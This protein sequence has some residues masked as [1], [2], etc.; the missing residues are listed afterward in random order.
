MS[1]P[2]RNKLK[3]PID[4]GNYGDV[5]FAMLLMSIVALLIIPLP[6]F[7]LDILLAT[8]IAIAVVL[9]LTSIYVTKPLKLSTFP[10]ILLVATLFRLALNVSS[11][12]LILGKGYAGEVIASFGE[13]VVQGNYVVGA[14]IFLILTLIQFLVIAKGS[15]RVAEVAARFTLDAMPGK[16]MS[17]DADLRAGAFGLDEARRRRGDVQMESRLFGAMDGAMK[18]VKGDA[19]AGDHHHPDQ[20]Y[21]R[22]DHRD[23][24]ARDER[25]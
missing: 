19:I 24:P 10:S 3:A 21:R 8:N 22:A 20:R 14:V 15:E 12:R 16:Q 1:S 7:L 11:T 4:W 18:F 5:F 23:H 6:T 25:R 2:S 9:L 13:F 17:I